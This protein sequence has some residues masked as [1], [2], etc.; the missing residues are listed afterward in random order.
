MWL[1]GIL[2]IPKVGLVS[3]FLISFVSATLVPMGSEPAVFAVIEANHALF[4]TVIAVATL[5]NTLGGVVDYWMGFYAKKIV[6]SG[7]DS[8]WHSRLQRLGPKSM[9]LAWVPVI[10]DPM[11][12]LA[13]WLRLPFWPSVGYMALGKCMRYMLMT[14]VL[15]A[16]PDGWWHRLAGWLA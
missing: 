14:N 3:V 10:G 16:V 2:A 7:L 1:L 11:C 6:A 13:G 5:G 9:L 4:W 15:L 8:R 12:T